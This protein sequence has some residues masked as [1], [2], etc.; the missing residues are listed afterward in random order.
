MVPP[1][2][3]SGIVSFVTCASADKRGSLRALETEEAVGKQ[4]RTN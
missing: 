2:Q 1:E 3:R 4:A